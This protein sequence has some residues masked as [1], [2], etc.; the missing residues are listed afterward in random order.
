M[1][2][3]AGPSRGGDHLAS[4]SVL[5]KGSILRLQVDT[6]VTLFFNLIV[7]LAENCVSNIT[8]NNKFAHVTKLYK[9]LKFLKLNKIYHLELPKF[10]HQLNYNR[11]FDVINLP[12]L[13]KFTHTIIDKARKHSTFYL[14]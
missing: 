7:S 5:L 11:L 8:W 4:G 2:P 10:M 6:I 12:K 1:R 3:W 13:R 14:G 9:E